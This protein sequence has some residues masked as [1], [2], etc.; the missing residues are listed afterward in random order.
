MAQVAEVDR[1]RGLRRTRHSDEDDVGFVEAGADPVVVLDRELH[2][3]DP[4]E[5]RRV[6]RRL[7]TG[8]HPRRLTGHACDRVDRVA[9]QI[10]VVHTCAATEAA[11]RVAHL[12]I[13]QRVDDDG[14]A[15]AGAADGDLE[16]L[17]RLGARVPHFL[18][19]LLG[20]LRLERVHEPRGRLAGGVRHDVQLDRRVRRH[21][22]ERTPRV[23]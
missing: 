4:A 15:P 9:E 14:R 16:I 23:R 12:R 18:E 6:E 2:R 19:V 21:G 13:H 22:A 10:A 1:E 7:R 5:V 3:L 17:H 20:K 8:C 11:H